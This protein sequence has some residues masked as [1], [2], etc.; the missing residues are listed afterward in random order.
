MDHISRRSS[1]NRKDD[2]EPPPSQANRVM[3]LVFAR[4]AKR[5]GTGGFLILFALL[6]SPQANSVMRLVFTRSAKRVGMG[7]FLIYLH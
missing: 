4:S 2:V 6:I 3:R 1:I 7:G 5:V